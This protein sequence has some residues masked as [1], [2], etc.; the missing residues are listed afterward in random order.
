ML[1]SFV[2]HAPHVVSPPLEKVYINISLFH[3][4]T[5]PRK[6]N[7]TGKKYTEHKVNFFFAPLIFWCVYFSFGGERTETMGS[8][9]TS[10]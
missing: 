9:R 7:I 4:L 3:L 6:Q 1:P 8:E 10:S 2:Q 5:P